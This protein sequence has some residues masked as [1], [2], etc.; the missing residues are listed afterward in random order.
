MQRPKRELISGMTVEEY[1]AWMKDS[2]DEVLM[3]NDSSS[4]DTIIE[5][6]NDE[7]YEFSV[8]EKNDFPVNRK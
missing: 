4:I 6:M 7:K 5:S 3:K 8:L 2:C 1:S